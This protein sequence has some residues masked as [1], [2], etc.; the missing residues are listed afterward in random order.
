[1]SEFAL[2]IG[3]RLYYLCIVFVP[4]LPSLDKV[5]GSNSYAR[6]TAVDI[7]CL[8]LSLMHVFVDFHDLKLLSEF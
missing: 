5:L 1:M 4:T 8:C 3:A 2:R 7:T 6:L